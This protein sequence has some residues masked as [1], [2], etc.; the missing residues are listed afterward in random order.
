V[1]SPSSR[2]DQARGA[3]EKINPKLSGSPI[4]TLDQA[5]RNGNVDQGNAT[6][7]PV[8]KGCVRY[9]A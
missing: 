7:V 5:L 6:K 9:K 1:G 8:M 2:K 4:V 3:D